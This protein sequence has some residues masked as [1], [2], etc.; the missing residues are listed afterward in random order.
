MNPEIA[1]LKARAESYKLLYKTKKVS[2]DEAMV[3]I[4]PYI[5]AVNVKATAIAKKFNV[6]PRLVTVTGFLR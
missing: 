1:A 3:N 6:R 5:D 2:R 4:Q